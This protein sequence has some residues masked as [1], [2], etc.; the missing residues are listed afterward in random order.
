MT[1]SS[2][3]KMSP[4]PIEDISVREG[5]G[6]V[7]KPNAAEMKRIRDK[8][9]EQL[10]SAEF[11]LL[12]EKEQRWVLNFLRENNFKNFADQREKVVSS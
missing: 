7:K 2:E 1:P 9:M 10:T 8:P 3:N 6:E 4:E 11:D 12:E 5:I